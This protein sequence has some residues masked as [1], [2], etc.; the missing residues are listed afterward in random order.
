MATTYNFPVFVWEDYG[1]LF[2]AS[3]LEYHERISAVG[4]TVD[5]ALKHLKEYMVWRYRDSFW[6]WKEGSE[7]LEPGVR[8]IKV[9][10]KPVYKEY[11]RVYP[12]QE[13]VTLRLPCVN[14]REQ[15]G[16]FV[17]L[18]P[19]IDVQFNY[20]DRG[21]LKNLAS[22]FAK[23]KLRGLTPQQLLKYLPPKSRSI[24]EITVVFKGTSKKKAK[25]SWRQNTM[26]EYLSVV[27]EPLR[28]G[29]Q[30]GKHSRAWGRDNEVK[31]LLSRLKSGKTNVLL[32]GDPGVGKTTIIF[33]AASK[34]ERESK[35][36]VNEYPYR[37]WITGAQRIIAGMPYLGQW[38]E[39][40]ENVIEELQDIDGVLCIEN[41]LELVKTGGR[42]PL[43]SI[44][45]F[46]M[47]YIKRGELQV[48][49]EATPAEID[50]C[51]RLLPGF[52][53][54]FQVMNIQ[55]LLEKEAKS[56]LD[57]IVKS[58]SQSL[59]IKA[60]GGISDLIYRLFGRFMPYSPFPGK[61]ATFLYDSCDRMKQE[62]KETLTGQFVLEHFVRK[63]GLPE[64]F[65]RDEITLNREKVLGEFR[66]KIIGQN[67]ACDAA[68][69]LVMTFKAG[70]NDPMRPLGVLLFSGPTGVGKT[71]LARAIADYFFGHGKVT[72][73]LIR[74]DM[75]E[76]S[77]PG[78]AKRI[79]SDPD[80][81]PSS[82]IKK[83][84]V[85]PFSV[86]LLDE[87]EKASPEVFDVFLTMFDEG[88]LADRYGRVSIFRSAIV[89]MTSNL[90]AK[91][92]DSIGF[93]E[94]PISYDAE[95]QSFF[96]P[97]FY[98]R[99]DMVVTFNPL[100]KETIL[101]IT[102]KELK[103]ISEREGLSANNIRLSW[104]E[105]ILEYLAEQGFDH[106]YGARQLQRTIERLLVTRLAQYLVTNL[107]LKEITIR[108]GLSRDRKV[109]FEEII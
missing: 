64:L 71:A 42:E 98:N 30:K 26:F 63:T 51:R 56:L 28:R 60:E 14:G 45:A 9:K 24:H 27:A 54:L 73:R 84:R 41:L 38:E 48:I 15:S 53:D 5:E 61:A 81:K 108:A 49:S 94:Q 103:E 105:E 67:E 19:T 22:H 44:A 75:S 88:R 101:A 90:G 97:E 93:K 20:Y 92:Q 80:G 107:D 36:N 96:R 59:R 8:D 2:T 100:S 69:K 46:L 62:N 74:L 77:G 58:A 99:I 87:I 34:L 13:T 66:K 70:M 21:A 33:E 47:P 4:K 52:V 83:I 18:L 12:C 35:K 106:K 23:D 109:T 1:G 17:C 76:Y 6:V 11:D 31:E 29:R 7:F 65:L 43:D 89:I 68:T 78:S 3:L 37:L 95:V 102:E 39:R 82:L 72:D 104:T 79:L 25:L 40:C 57:Q 32:S 16:M 85:Q 91:H 50:A 86:V 10:I 55:A